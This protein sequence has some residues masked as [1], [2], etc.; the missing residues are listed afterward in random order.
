MRH[1][2]SRILSIRFLILV[3]LGVLALV[4]SNVV[5]PA[6]VSA[7]SASLP[8]IQ[9]TPNH[10]PWFT[11]TVV[12]GQGF[13]PNEQVGIYKQTRPFFA[14]ETDSTGSFVG[15]PHPMMG[16]GPVSGIITI[17]GIGRKS[18]LKANTT[19]TVTP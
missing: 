18:G 6:G 9:I 10:G 8:A 3:G 14:Y 19:F 4:L 13:A 12:T 15:T 5:V 16:P 7:A 1:P 17:T 2:N 11:V